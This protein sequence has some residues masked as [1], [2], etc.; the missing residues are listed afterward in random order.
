MNKLLKFK[1]DIKKNQKN[2]KSTLDV[3]SKEVS[4]KKSRIIKPYIAE[5]KECFKDIDYAGRKVDEIMCKNSASK[6]K[7]KGG[8]LINYSKNMKYMSAPDMMEYEE[9]RTGVKPKKN[10]EQIFS[11]N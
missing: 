8:N 3:I 10:S 2:L 11:Y 7:K 6:E 9:D 5:I 1:E 4:I